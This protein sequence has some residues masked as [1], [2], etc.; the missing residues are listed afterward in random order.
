MVGALAAVLYK[1]RYML[2]RWLR[3]PK[4]GSSWDPDR[5]TVLKRRIEDAEA[6]KAWLNEKESS[7]GGD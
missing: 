3:D 1:F 5:K 7:E 6:E 2:R 4:Y